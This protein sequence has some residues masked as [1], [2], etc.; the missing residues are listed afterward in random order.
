MLPLLLLTLFA[1]SCA[2]VSVHS[3]YDDTAD[4]A[5]Y[6]TFGF[7]KDGIDK[8]EISDLDKKRI[9][10]AL[11][12]ELNAKGL[13]KSEK[14]DMY[15][16]FFTKANKEVNVNNFG[17]GWGWGG[18]WGW[19]PYWGG[20]WGWGGNYTSV[21]TQTE[22]TLYVDVIDAGKKELVWQGVGN[23]VLTQNREKKQARINEFA[24][25]IL[26]QFPPEKKK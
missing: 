2:S 20:P 17:N 5:T 25:A 22:G 15:V 18:G 4:F 14:P 21:S 16:N 19:G 10:K 7:L 1:V 26:K 8:A 12:A 13:T 9:M 24:K 11:E 3:D 23:G 6:K